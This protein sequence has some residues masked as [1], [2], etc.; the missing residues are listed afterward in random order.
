MREGQFAFYFFDDL[1]S[2]PA[3]LRRRVLNFL[4]V[5]PGLPSGHL[6]PGFNRKSNSLKVPLSEDVREALVEHFA[7]EIRTCADSLGGRA[8]EWR[9]K[10][11]L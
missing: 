9:A 2:D 11:N 7:D 5:D 8:V 6:D 1:K 3:E 10:Y 4:G